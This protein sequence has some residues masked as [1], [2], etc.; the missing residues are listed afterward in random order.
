MLNF[1]FYISIVACERICVDEIYVVTVRLKIVSE[2]SK[3]RAILLILGCGLLQIF[4]GGI[5]AGT[6]AIMDRCHFQV[7]AFQ[8]RSRIADRSMVTHPKIRHSCGCLRNIK[9]EAHT[10]DIL[11]VFKNVSVENHFI[12]EK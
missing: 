12:Q 5:H 3:F 9:K 4:C 10:L 7:V 2:W 6:S 11:S 1:R 8:E